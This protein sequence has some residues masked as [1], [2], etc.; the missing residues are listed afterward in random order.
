MNPAHAL[1]IEDNKRN[2]DVLVMLLE[3]EGATSVEVQNRAQLESVLDGD[4]PFDV[5]FLDLELPNM[6]GFEIAEHLKASPRFQTVPVIAYTVHLSE[7]G[8]VRDCGFDGFLGKP[9]DT[10]RFPELFSRIL[11]GEQVWIAI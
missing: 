1:I 7:I 6:N 3:R 5:V 11:N 2:R 10:D 4:D 8:A 9:I